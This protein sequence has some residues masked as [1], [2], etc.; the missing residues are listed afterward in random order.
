MAEI[1]LTLKNGTK[2]HLSVAIF[3]TK[4]IADL[5]LLG[6]CIPGTIQRRF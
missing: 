4:N 5:G 1:L 2:E 6:V 3:L